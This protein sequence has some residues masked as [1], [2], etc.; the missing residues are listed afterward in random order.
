MLNAAFYKL[1]IFKSLFLL[2][3]SQ[4]T[5]DTNHY[6]L[7]CYFYVLLHRHLKEKS[8][9]CV[10]VSDHFNCGV[11]VDC[12]F[13]TAGGTSAQFSQTDI[14]LEG[15]PLEQQITCSAQY[16]NLSELP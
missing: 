5:Y 14:M 3:L 8:L 2:S 15:S 9:N 1:Y 11:T 6:L 12:L 16:S 4:D 7:T 13:L 10:C